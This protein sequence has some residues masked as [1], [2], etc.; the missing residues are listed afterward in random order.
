MGDC[1]SLSFK[2]CLGVNGVQD[3]KNVRSSG[4][5][6]LK[7]TA[8]GQDSKSLT[9]AARSSG[10]EAGA[11]AEVQGAAVPGDQK[12]KGEDKNNWLKTKGRY[13]QCS[14][15]KEFRKL[16]RLGEG[17]L[18]GQVWKQ[19]GAGFGVRTFYFISSVLP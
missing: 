18:R 14:K 2:K 6:G 8:R 19:E 5:E 17:G 10:G 13:K 16:D 15:E 3:L 1:I 12:E 4:K 11:H 7:S 9:T